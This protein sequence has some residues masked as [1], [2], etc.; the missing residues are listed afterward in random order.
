VEHLTT[1]PE[2]R[3]TSGHQYAPAHCADPLPLQSSGVDRYVFVPDGLI[4]AFATAAKHRLLPTWGRDQLRNPYPWRFDITS[5][6]RPAHV[7]GRRVPVTL[8]DIYLAWLEPHAGRGHARISRYFVRPLFNLVDVGAY[9]IGLR[10]EHTPTAQ[11]THLELVVNSA[12]PEVPDVLTLISR[13][14]AG[15]LTVID[16]DGSETVVEPSAPGYARFAACRRDD[17]VATQR[18][19]NGSLNGS[20]NGSARGSIS[21]ASR[22]AQLLALKGMID[23]SAPAAAPIA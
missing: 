7:R 13:A 15:L 5:G 9:T 11:L 20:A 8:L 19:A 4:S 23:A 10:L 6:G 3:R 17:A 2:A 12:Y 18:P 21:F 1:S 16:D 14:A 22:G